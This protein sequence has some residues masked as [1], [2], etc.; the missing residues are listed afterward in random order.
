MEFTYIV[1]G[2]PIQVNHSRDLARSFSESLF[3]WAGP[4]HTGMAGTGIARAEAGLALLNESITL[5]GDRDRNGIKGE[6]A[7]Q[8]DEIARAIEAIDALVGNRENLIGLTSDSDL[9]RKRL[10][11]GPRYAELV[12]T[13]DQAFADRRAA[14]QQMFTAVAADDVKAGR[15]AIDLADAGKRH[16]DRQI[17]AVADSIIFPALPD[18]K[19]FALARTDTEAL[20]RLSATKPTARQMHS[21]LDSGLN[22]VPAVAK[23]WI[24]YESEKPHMLTDLRWR[25]FEERE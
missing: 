5:L 3:R 16:A 18:E 11:T 13:C 17:S 25:A 2:H 22:A 10:L 8:R 7:L 6:L 14:D 4:A 19:L 12:N 15:A 24:I 23:L 21:A 9:L 20:R 1:N